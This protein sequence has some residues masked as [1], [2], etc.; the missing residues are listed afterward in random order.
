M[1][2]I[3]NTELSPLG[4]EEENGFGSKKVNVQSN[5]IGW[6]HATTDSEEADFDI[7]IKDSLGRTKAEKRGC[8]ASVSRYGELINIPTVIGE[9]IEI[10]VE[11][12]KC[13]KKIDVFIN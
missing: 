1:R 2:T 7:I 12:V 3:L 8:H 6:I 10:C 9:E 5:K 4:F 11:N 13:A